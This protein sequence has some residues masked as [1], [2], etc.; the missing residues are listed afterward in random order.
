MIQGESTDFR[1]RSGSH[2]TI[3]FWPS[4]LE[5]NSLP[6]V[7]RPVWSDHPASSPAS[8]SSCPSHTMF[9]LHWPPFW[10]SN[11]PN[12][13][14]AWLSGQHLMAASVPCSHHSS[15]AHPN[16]PIKSGPVSTTSTSSL[17]NTELLIFL[18][19]LFTIC[20]HLFTHLLFIFTL[21]IGLYSTSGG[22]GHQLSAHSCFPWGV[23]T[24]SGTQWLLHQHLLK[25]QINRWVNTIQ[26]TL[27]G[28]WPQ[29]SSFFCV[30]PFL[31]IDYRNTYLR[32]WL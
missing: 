24:V 25:E 3:D 28:V 9:S 14:A 27:L 20:T 32:D 11:A 16:H 26:T 7:L 15:E 4:L 6:W 18:L 29:S 13:S 12:P 31:F 21:S 22:Q 23:S 10:S 30:P 19:E 17:L 8:L 1:F 2:H 5:L